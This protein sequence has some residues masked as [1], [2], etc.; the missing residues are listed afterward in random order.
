MDD[1]KKENKMINAETMTMNEMFGY[2]MAS[3]G[4]TSN[5]TVVEVVSALVD[6]TRQAHEE[7]ADIAGMI[8]YD[9]T[10]GVVKDYMDV[11]TENEGE[12]VSNA[13]GEVV[14]VPMLP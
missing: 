11:L 5:S 1:N 10:D 13:T 3:R 12:Y 9:F 14:S 7:V 6:T 2:M 8:I 4:V